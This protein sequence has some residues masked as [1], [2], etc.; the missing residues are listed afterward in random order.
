MTKM[1]PA[2]FDYQA[3]SSPGSLCCFTNYIP[4]VEAVLEARAACCEADKP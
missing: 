3:P 1:N 4:I 2:T